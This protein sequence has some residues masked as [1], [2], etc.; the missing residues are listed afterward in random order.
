[1]AIGV[2]DPPAFVANPG[3]KHQP[4]AAEHDTPRSGLTT[5]FDGLGVVWIDHEVPFQRSMRVNCVLPD[6]L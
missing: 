3:L 2:L 6:E 5:S 4:V 1:M